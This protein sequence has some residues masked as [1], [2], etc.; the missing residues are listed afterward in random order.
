MLVS[1]AWTVYYISPPYLSNPD[2]IVAVLNRGVLN[3]G[4]AKYTNLGQMKVPFLWRC[5]TSGVSL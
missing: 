1:T 5:P 4:V 3:S 2:T